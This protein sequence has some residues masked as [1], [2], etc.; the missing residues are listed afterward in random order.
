MRIA[1][2]PVQ[3]DQEHVYAHVHEEV[4]EHEGQ[5]AEQEGVLTGLPHRL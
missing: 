1:T 3:V 5:E 4:Q 2:T